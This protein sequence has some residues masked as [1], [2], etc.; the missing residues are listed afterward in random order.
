[1]KY[2]RTAVSI[3]ISIATLMAASLNF[4]CTRGYVETA[5]LERQNQGPSAC[6][7]RCQELGMTMGALVLVSNS[8]PACVCEPV[9]TSGS[10]IAGSAG[11][12]GGEV[13]VAAAAAQAQQDQ[14]RRQ[15]QAQQAS[16]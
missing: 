9:A 7:S 2:S 1:M 4:A 8:T 3:A 5:D 12:A 15:Q 11:A 6:Y 13:V 14:M 10:P 16:R